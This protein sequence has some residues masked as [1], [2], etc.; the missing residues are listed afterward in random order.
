MCCL[1]L[2]LLANFPTT[3]SGPGGVHDSDIAPRSK[4]SRPVHVPILNRWSHLRQSLAVR[5]K[6]AIFALQ[7]SQ[8]LCLW[9][10]FAHALS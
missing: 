7:C 1:V 10:F 2:L 3:R 6:H 8:N 4:V 5:D 9:V